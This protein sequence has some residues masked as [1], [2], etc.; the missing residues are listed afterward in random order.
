MYTSSPTIAT[1]ALSLLAAL[2]SVQAGGLYT[3]NSPVIQVDAKNYDRLVAKSNYTT[4]CQGEKTMDP[5]SSY[6]F[7]DKILTHY[8]S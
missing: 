3:K 4:V 7:R 2:P 1:I 6:A 5:A 8:L